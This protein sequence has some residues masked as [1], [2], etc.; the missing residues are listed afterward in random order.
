[1]LRARFWLKHAVSVLKLMRFTSDSHASTLAYQ[2]SCASPVQM[3]LGSL[4]HV[5]RIRRWLY[6][7]DGRSY[8]NQAVVLSATGA[9]AGEEETVWQ[10]SDYEDCGPEKT[11]EAG[12]EGNLTGKV[13]RFP[14]RPARYIR[15]YAGR[16]NVMD[17]Y[18]TTLYNGGT[19]FCTPTTPCHRCQGD[20][21]T[22]NDCNQGLKCFQRN[23][24][25]AVPGCDDGGAGDVSDHDYCYDSVYDQ[26]IYGDI[27]STTLYNGGT[28]FCTPTT[29][30]HRCQGDCD[31]DND[32]NQGLK[33]FQRDGHTAV[34]GCD[35][36]GGGDVF[37]YDYCYD[38]GID[39][40][41]NHINAATH[42]TE[43]QVFG[44]WDM[45]SSTQMVDPT[46]SGAEVY[47]S[48]WT[49]RSENQK[50]QLEL[51]ANG[52]LVVRDRDTKAP[53]IWKLGSPGE[54]CNAVCLSLG[55]S[56]HCD[57]ETTA[58]G[59]SSH[60][61]FLS[62]L[63]QVAPVNVS[64]PVQQDGGAGGPGW[65]SGV[66]GAQKFLAL[67]VNFSSLMPLATHR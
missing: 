1:M 28:S 15:Y 27:H 20:C 4:A 13:I 57:R 16:S 61:D 51:L 30:C 31:T 66:N 8:C 53:A 6:Y 18:G 67:C 63:T 54:N 38:P 35:E 24:H 32:C 49:L 2:I 62:I 43:V 55:S 17:L 65:I 10:C 14:S 33:C 19:S 11:E 21:D 26:V 25:T 22:D 7:G 5:S 56:Y 3:D 59:A 45:E 41:I 46:R 23:G 50:Y 58:T 40:V 34:P 36:G 48:G 64:D 47:A 9:F 60:A 39:Q 12:F 37:D 52:D 44:T 29:P 42:F